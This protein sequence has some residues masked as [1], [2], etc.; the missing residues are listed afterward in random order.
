MEARDIALLPAFTG[1]DANRKCKKCGYA[2]G[3]EFEHKGWLQLAGMETVHAMLNTC[4]N[5]CY[6]W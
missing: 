6:E 4:K 5:C 1:H 3:T 2:A